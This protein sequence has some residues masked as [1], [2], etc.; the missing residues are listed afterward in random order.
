MKKNQREGKEWYERGAKLWWNRE[1]ENKIEELEWEVEKE[2][3]EVV[4]KI[5]EKVENSLT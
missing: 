2:Y 1:V 5:E 3:E 4:K